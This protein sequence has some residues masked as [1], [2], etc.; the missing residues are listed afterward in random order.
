ML[1]AICASANDCPA[2]AASRAVAVSGLV[3]TDAALAAADG[4]K[5][6]RHHQCHGQQNE[7]DDQRD[8]AL[9]VTG[10]G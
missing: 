2:S 9:A 7:R 4:Q 6:Q 5:R 3:V 8:A 1:A 10:D